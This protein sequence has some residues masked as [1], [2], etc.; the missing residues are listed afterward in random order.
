MPILFYLAFI[1]V[2]FIA[3]FAIQ[4]S[5]ASPV[6]I[7]FLSWKFET[8]LIYALLGSVCSGILVTLLFWLQRSIR[9]SRRTKDSAPSGQDKEGKG[10]V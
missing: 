9:S 10:I 8:S 1:V 4:N 2:I 5:N 3:I 7:R 6:L